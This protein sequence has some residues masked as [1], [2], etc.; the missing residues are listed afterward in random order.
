MNIDTQ[1]L[2]EMIQ[3]MINN[4]LVQGGF[5][6]PTAEVQEPVKVLPTPEYLVTVNGEVVGATIADDDEL[7]DLIQSVKGA[8]SDA[9]VNVY[10]L[11]NTDADAEDYE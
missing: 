3:G 10:L 6:Q 1:E 8:N 2:A 11:D 4:A 9:K 7:F 5:I